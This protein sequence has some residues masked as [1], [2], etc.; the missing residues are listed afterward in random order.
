MLY[1]LQAAI[2]SHSFPHSAGLKLILPR[3]HKRGCSLLKRCTLILGWLFFT[4]QTFE[5]STLHGW[6]IFLCTFRR[7]MP[8]RMFSLEISCLLADET[9]SNHVI[10]QT[11]SR[12]TFFVGSKSDI[13]VIRVLLVMKH[14]LWQVA[15]L[16]WAIAQIKHEWKGLLCS[17]VSS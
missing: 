8:L 6:G 14:L 1:I 7:V 9:E 3:G 11:S 5:L 13:L 16:G 12:S 15:Q 10:L 4:K 17:G 2:V